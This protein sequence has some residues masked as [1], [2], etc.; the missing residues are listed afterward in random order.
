MKGANN[1]FYIFPF[2]N[3]C[4]NHPQL[5]D[6][7][8]C[9]HHGLELAVS[10]EEITAGCP[11]EEFLYYNISH[12]STKTKTADGKIRNPLLMLHG[13]VKKLRCAN[14]SSAATL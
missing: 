3:P 12:L 13:P 11:S 1:T 7:N 10:E 6:A 9:S 2:S 14:L 5:A 4:A 8:C